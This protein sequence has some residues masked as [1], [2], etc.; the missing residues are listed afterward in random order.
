ML[1]RRVLLPI[2]RDAIRRLDNARPGHAALDAING[3]VDVGVTAGCG[4]HLF[5]KGQQ[6]DDDSAE[7]L[8]WYAGEIVDVVQ[9]G[10][11]VAVNSLIN[12]VDR[13]AAETS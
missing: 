3:L 6:H 4:R 5:E 8:Y 10:A 11:W 2:V 7:T 13:F 1:P 9:T 12:C